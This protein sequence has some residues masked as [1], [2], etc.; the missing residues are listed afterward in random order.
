MSRAMPTSG[1]LVIHERQ[2][3]P[4]LRPLAAQLCLRRP[5]ACKLPLQPQ[6]LS[7]VWR[8]RCDVVPPGRDGV[9]AL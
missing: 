4:Q 2:Q 5:H 8:D 6:C 9:G 1:G 7:H 3:Q